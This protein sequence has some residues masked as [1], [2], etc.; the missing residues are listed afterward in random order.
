MK[1]LSTDLFS[2]EIPDEFE[3]IELTKIGVRSSNKS[4]EFKIQPPDIAVRLFM[5]NDLNSD[6]YK[7]DK[8][9]DKFEDW[10]LS[11][12]FKSEKINF[13]EIEFRGYKT[14]IFHAHT[15]APWQDVHFKLQY[16]HVAI[17][18]EDT[19]FLEVKIIHEKIPSGQIDNWVLPV[20]ESIEILGDANLRKQAWAEH[21]LDMDKESREYEEALK[22]SQEFEEEDKKKEFSEVHIPKNGE[23]FI[24]IGDFDFEFEADECKIEIAE[25]SKELL[26]TLQ[27][28]TSKSSKAIKKELL[29][30][31][32]GDGLVTLTIPAKGIHVS[33]VPEGQLYFEEEKTNAP[34]FLNAR[35][36][37][38][39]YSLAF[40]GS[41]TFDSG[42]VLLKG[43][44]TK[45]YTKKAFPVRIAKKFEMADLKWNNY[46]FTSMEE[47]ATA[48][49]LDVCF[50]HIERPD[51]KALPEA[52][53]SFE[54]LEELTVSN[55]V[56][57]WEEIELPMLAIASA[58]G[59]LTQLKSLY[60]NGLAIE[61]LPESIVHLKNLEHLSINNC[62]LKE[63]PDGIWQLPK[64]KFLWLSSNELTRIS[65]EINLPELQ[66][67]SLNRNKFKTLP[68]ALAELSKLKKIDLKDNP[69]GQLPD[70]F[71]QIE[72]IELAMEDKLRLLDFSYKGADGNGLVE[73]ND[74]VFWAQY[75][76]D[77][78][79]EIDAVIKEN[80]LQIHSSALV[81]LVKKSIS[82][83]H[84]GE[85]DYSKVGNHRFGGMP[86]LPEHINYPR[87]GE[88]WRDTKEDYVYE[89]LGQINCAEI[90]H[91]QDYLPRTGMLFFFLETIH[92][93]YGGNNN[94]SK[95]IYC[96]DNATLASGKR[97]KFTEDDYSEMI[98]GGY[99]GYKVNAKKINSAPSF[100]ASYAN[101]HLFLGEAE[102]LKEDTDLHET[103]YDG[104]E[105]PLNGDN[106]FD[107]AV[108]AYGFSQHEHPEL[109][110][111]LKKKGNPQDWIIL[112]TVTSSGDM[113]WGDAG[114]L[115]F[116][117][118]K[119]DLAKGD[120]SNVFI[121]MESS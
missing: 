77:L 81:S 101:T 61:K 106:P 58:I 10:C 14:Y 98:D 7:G 45:S 53:F 72:A 34:L 11:L 35:S 92:N 64:L 43:E 121:T 89:F 120:F 113:Q 67:I 96:D 71:N 12:H 52:I 93:F 73:W 28:K 33:G 16:F 114:D 85:E 102:S 97:F 80:K 19:Y 112:L 24:A 60:I 63:V 27:A 109:Q 44:M 62:S 115:F 75:D 4:P 74:E 26:V 94:P 56:N 50:L 1:T 104:F 69:L 118:H 82:F 39:D 49:P 78:L 79:P 119:S 15:D 38:F 68:E 66:N 3:T 100:Y 41:V 51:F 57:Y 88:N 117:I 40:C 116:V 46:R 18:L 36:E 32:P 84:D 65:E 105:E 86:D 13:E 17:F 83:K 2:I 76:T 91:L 59:K 20:F 108:N 47:I 30:D 29:S 42:W 6:T 21:L 111:S 90:A 37:G 54:N 87:F 55:P 95:V 99:Q 103:L 31:Y 25:F 110:A 23:E 48:N 9:G 70:A 5:V 8:I 22:A 107:Y